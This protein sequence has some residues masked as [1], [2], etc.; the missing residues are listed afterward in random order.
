MALD[1]A[2]L[3]TAIKTAFEKSKNT[4]PPEN[5]DEID[6]VQ[7]Q[8][9]ETLAQDLSAAIETFVRSG[10]VNGVSVTVRDNAN[11]VIGSGVQSVA[12]KVM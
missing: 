8:I 3:R 2:T 11:N 6:Q 5:P 4:P 9:L 7:V 10:D 1:V 12:V